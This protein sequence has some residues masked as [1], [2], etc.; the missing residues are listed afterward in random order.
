MKTVV[1][2]L[3]LIYSISL[4][5]CK[6]DPLPG[7]DGS[8]YFVFGHFY[9][10]CQG[11]QC[12]E[13]FK[14]TPDKLQEDSKDHYPNRTDFYIGEYKDLSTLKYQKAKDLVTLLPDSLLLKPNQ[15]FGCADCADGGGLYIEYK[16][17]DLHN[18]WIIDQNKNQIP[19]FLHS[20]TD[21]V[22]SVIEKISD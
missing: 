6:K 20:F 12:I 8:D 4:V 14:V 15:E 19:K 2:L 9:G 3:T 17:G 5:G 13:I 11:E 22:N 1:T 7:L 21:S 16:K 10:E 18:F